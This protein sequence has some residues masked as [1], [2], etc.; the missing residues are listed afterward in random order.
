M[1]LRPAHEH[2]SYIDSSSM[3]SDS[4]AELMLAQERIL[5]LKPF[6]IDGSI[7]PVAQYT[8]AH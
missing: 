2:S 5:S 1:L 8:H 4:S 7:A 3:A 6:A